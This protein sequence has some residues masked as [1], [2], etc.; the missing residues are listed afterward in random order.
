MREYIRLQDIEENG[1]VYYNS[2]L[3]MV[4]ALIPN[5]YNSCH[6]ADLLELP[7]WRFALLLVCGF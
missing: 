6:A 3:D 7:K 4:E 1:K 2:R 5:P